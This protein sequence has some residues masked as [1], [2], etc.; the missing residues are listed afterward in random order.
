MEWISTKSILPKENQIIL[1]KIKDKKGER[2]IQKLIRKGNL[3]Y[4]TDFKMYVYYAPNYWK[5]I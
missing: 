1:T 4:T 3:W 2:N 5:P